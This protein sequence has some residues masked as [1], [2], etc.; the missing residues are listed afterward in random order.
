MSI[1]DKAL[2]ELRRIISRHPPA[3][4]LDAIVKLMATEEDVR[5][6]CC[7]GAGT[8]KRPR[9]PNITKEQAVRLLEDL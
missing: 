3:G 6:P 8:I 9:E 5:C 1:P 7:Q 4:R 2:P